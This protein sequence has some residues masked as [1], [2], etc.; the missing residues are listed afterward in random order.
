MSTNTNNNSN[1]IIENPLEEE[2]ESKLFKKYNIS[3]IQDISPSIE[4]ELSVMNSTTIS[5]NEEGIIEKE[6]NATQPIIVEEQNNILNE[7]LFYGNNINELKP[8]FLGNMRA[9]LYYKN[10]P[11]II[12]GP[13]CKYFIIYLYLIR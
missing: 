12:I 8:K 5:N 6:N 13:D 7:N 2:A 3:N 11:L 9:F 10:S 1:E 4:T